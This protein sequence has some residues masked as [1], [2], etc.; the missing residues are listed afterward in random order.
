MCSSSCG[1]TKSSL[2]HKRLKTPTNL[3]LVVGFL[4]ERLLYHYLGNQWSQQDQYTQ[5]NQE[6]NL[7]ST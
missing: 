3:Y 4:Y 1:K 7:L 5:G 2:M 6:I